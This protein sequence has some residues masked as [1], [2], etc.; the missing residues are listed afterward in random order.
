MG[1]HGQTSKKMKAGECKLK[2]DKTRCIIAIGFGYGNDSID[3]F[4]LNEIEEIC[5]LVNLVNKQICNLV[6]SIWV[7]V[8]LEAEWY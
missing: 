6:G 7:R 4:Q 3:V 5:N 2:T 1:E 8:D